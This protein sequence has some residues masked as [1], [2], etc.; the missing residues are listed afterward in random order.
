MHKAIQARHVTSKTTDNSDNP[1][2]ATF[3]DNGISQLL[4]CKV[5]AITRECITIL[6]LSLITANKELRREMFDRS[7][8][9]ACKPITHSYNT[10]TASLNNQMKPL[11]LE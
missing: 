8:T 5:R 11:S 3:K 6:F 9:R 2:G 7:K 10:E 4:L 1:I